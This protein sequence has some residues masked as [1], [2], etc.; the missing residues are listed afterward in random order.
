MITLRIDKEC[1]KPL[2][3]EVASTTS[4]HGDN[5]ITVRWQNSR[6]EIEALSR[7]RH[8]KVEL[9]VPD[10]AAMERAASAIGAACSI[11]NE[12]VV[13]AY[14][15]IVKTNGMWR[16]F[17][18]QIGPGVSRATLLKL[19]NKNLRN[20][21]DPKTIRKVLV[22]CLFEGISLSDI[23]VLAGLRGSGIIV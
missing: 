6:P 22:D 12:L 16:E 4:E 23:D 3:L 7:Y 21:I 19:V 17:N 18:Q 13:E 10:L 14:N 8:R 20:G 9:V 5:V 11:P 15:R 1:D 2:I